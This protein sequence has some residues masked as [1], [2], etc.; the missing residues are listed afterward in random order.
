[1]RYLAVA[2]VLA[3]TA[4]FGHQSDPASGVLVPQPPP[5][6]HQAIRGMVH[7]SLLPTAGSLPRHPAPQPAP[8]PQAA[9]V[10]AIPL[11]QVP[12][13]D[14]IDDGILQKGASVSVD[15]KIF[16]SPPAPACR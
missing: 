11:L 2:A 12:V 6:F 15:P 5:A 13:K 3:A 8:A 9:K 1:M 7:A 16:I 10:C 4:A 14:H